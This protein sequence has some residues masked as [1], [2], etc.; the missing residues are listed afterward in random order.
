MSMPPPTSE[1]PAF[2]ELF[3]IDDHD[4]VRRPAL[5]AS[6]TLPARQSWRGFSACGGRQHRQW[7][8]R[9]SVACGQRRALCPRPRPDHRPDNRCE[10]RAWCSIDSARN[11]LVTNKRKQVTPA[12]GCRGQMFNRRSARLRLTLTFPTSCREQASSASVRPRRRKGTAGLSLTHSDVRT[13]SRLGSPGCRTHS[14]Q[15]SC[16]RRSNAPCPRRA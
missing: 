4:A 2:A 13:R 15:I 12:P 1:R 10:I 11:K 14:S 3:L 6:A 5:C 9:W 8:C 7:S 16:H